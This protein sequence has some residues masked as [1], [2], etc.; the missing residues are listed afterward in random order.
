[1]EVRQCLRTRKVLHLSNSSS[2]WPSSPSWRSRHPQFASYRVKAYNAA[3]QS[4]LRNFQDPDGIGNGGQSAISGFRHLNIAVATI[5]K[6]D[7]NYEEICCIH[8]NNVDVDRC[9]PCICFFNILRICCTYQNSVMGGGSYS[10][11]TNV[12]LK[13]YST[14]TKYCAVQFTRVRPCQQGKEYATK[15]SDSTLRE[16]RC[17]LIRAVRRVVLL[18]IRRLFSIT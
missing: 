15:D 14:T 13:V 8:G 18:L 4:D 12:Q 11:S 3:A 2:W 17:N 6:G 16:R 5:T 1:M 9:S 7:Y 10:P